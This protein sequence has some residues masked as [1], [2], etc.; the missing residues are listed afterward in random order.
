MKKVL[1]T[2][3][4]G[5]I[6]SHCL[7]PLIARGFEVHAVHAR[8]EQLPKSSLTWHRA[9]LLDPVALAALVRD[10]QPTHLLHLAWYVTPGK[11]IGAVANLHWTKATLE[12]YESFVE[13]GGVRAVSSGSSYEYDWR[14]GYCT[15]ALTPCS[16]DTTYGVC[17]QALGELISAYADIAGLSSAW[18]RIF[19]VYGPREHPDRL[20]SSAVRSLLQEAPANCSHGEQIRDYLHAQDVADALVS[21]LDSELRGP[22]NIGSGIPIALKEVVRLIGVKLD[23]PD[24]VKL[25]AIP[26][27]ANDAPFVVADPTRLR[28]ELGWR[29]SFDLDTGLDQT[30]AWWR[31]EG[32][33]V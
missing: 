8:A 28:D 15:E 23:R 14:Y 18:A 6:G 10:V 25:G 20:V 24:L 22:V 32:L 11:V 29:P 1:V 13:H 26:A 7:Q 31:D 27:R 16:P 12:L 3:A 21:I 2:G 19:F 33:R 30:I 4:S 17:K 5:F 9:D